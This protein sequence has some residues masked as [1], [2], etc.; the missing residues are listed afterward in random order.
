MDPDLGG[1]PGNLGKPSPHPHRIGQWKGH[2]VRAT[3]GASFILLGI[4][5]SQSLPFS[6]PSGWPLL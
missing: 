2:R 5:Q 6:L 3:E 1:D 4:L